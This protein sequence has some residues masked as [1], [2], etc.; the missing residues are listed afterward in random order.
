MSGRTEN[1]SAVIGIELAGKRLD[2]A[3]AALFPDFS[4]SR[5]QQWLK[6]GLVTLDGRACKA[7]EKVVGGERVQLEAHLDD[8]V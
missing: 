8:Q 5:L 7:K 1:Y 3:L 4:R 2:Q 6:E